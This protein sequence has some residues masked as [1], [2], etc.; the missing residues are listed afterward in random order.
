MTYISAVIERINTTKLYLVN[1]F[2]TKK[3]RKK[4][5]SIC[6]V[7]VILISIVCNI[8]TTKNEVVFSDLLSENIEALAD[9]ESSIGIAF[10]ALVNSEIC[11]IYPDG[12]FVIGYRQY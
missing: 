7:I 5:L 9:G 1:L 6:S 4:I 8:V 2:K 11:I 12:Y 10:C 3:M